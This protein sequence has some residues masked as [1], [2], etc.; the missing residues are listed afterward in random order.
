MQHEQART[1][2]SRTPSM[3]MFLMSHHGRPGQVQE[4][5]SMFHAKFMTVSFQLMV[6]PPCHHQ[7]HGRAIFMQWP[8]HVHANVQGLPST[9][10]FQAMFRPMPTFMFMPP[11]CSCHVF[12]M[13]CSCHIAMVFPAAVQASMAAMQK[14]GGKK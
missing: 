7:F 2:M 1:A 6:M 13:L 9:C 10:H 4:S 3:C 12:V 14:G 8:Y 5:D 11:L